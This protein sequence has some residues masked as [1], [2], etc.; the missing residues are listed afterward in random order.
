MNL[1]SIPLHCIANLPVCSQTWWS[2]VKSHAGVAEMHSWYL[3]GLK[4]ALAYKKD[5]YQ[6]VRWDFFGLAWKLFPQTRYCC[7]AVDLH[8]LL[9]FS[10]KNKSG[11]CCG[12][13]CP[14]F[15]NV[16]CLSEATF[17]F[18]RIQGNIPASHQIPSETV[19][20]LSTLNISFSVFYKQAQ[21]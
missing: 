16:W 1:C 18:W 2:A 12:L 5:K 21:C 7:R 15:M 14:T 19:F 11:F 6:M 3:S 4:M 10:F 13:T 17:L 9:F 8:F 20:W